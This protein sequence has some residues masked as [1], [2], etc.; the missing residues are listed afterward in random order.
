MRGQS[1]PVDT[2]YNTIKSRS[3]HANDVNWGQMDS[4]F[5]TALKTAHSTDDTL[6]GFIEIF[7][8]M[9]DVHSSLQYNQK[10]YNYYHAV[11]SAT[12]HNIQPLLLK[13]RMETGVIRVAL[14]DQQYAYIQIPAILGYGDVINTY[15][16]AIHD[17][18]CTFHNKNITG[19]I[20]D[21]RLNSGGNMY[22]MLGGLSCFFDDQ[23]IG[24][25]R[26][27]DNNILFYWTIHHHQFCFETPDER[28]FPLSI[29]I[30]PASLIMQKC[31]W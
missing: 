14:I 4:I 12:S 27:R 1:V 8:A 19:F 5:Y 22:P 20:I 7:K 13:M 6:A 23:P 29:S 18:I 10:T 11:D 26:D 28:I 30:L 17:S 3:V 9:D 31:R 15:T 16:Q 21:L 2:I 24:S 25:V